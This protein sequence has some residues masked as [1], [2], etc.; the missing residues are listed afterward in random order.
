M[1][2]VSE[3]AKQRTNPKVLVVCAWYQR[4]AYI[5]DTV[6]SLLSQ[7]YDNFEI[8]VINDGSP[9]PRVAKILNTY[10][11]AKLHV[12]HQNN[13]GFTTAIRRAIEL[14]PSKYICVMGAGDLAHPKKITTQVAYLENHSK[15][16]AVGTGHVLVSARTKRRIT[17]RKPARKLDSSSLRTRVPFTHG[18]IM[19]RRSAY[20]AVN[21]YDTFFKIGQDRDLYWRLSSIAEIHGI[22][23]PLYEKYLFDESVSFQPE[24]VVYRDFF[25]KLAKSQNRSQIEYYRARP[26]LTPTLDMASD[27]KYLPLTIRRVPAMLIR[28]EWLLAIRWNRLALRQV[29]NMLC[30][31]CRAII[32]PK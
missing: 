11:D 15:V 23:E 28:G 14:R 20:E 1:T 27:P 24:M 7:D 21:G 13:S 2:T 26:D 8:V 3:K 29:G 32:T 25:A 10:Q 30:H 12:V 18:T 6:G 19:Y 5:I 31:A 16:G 22:D 9:D 4:A 17:Y